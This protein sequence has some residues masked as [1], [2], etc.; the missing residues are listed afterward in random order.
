[1]SD[2][3]YKLLKENW[4]NYIKEDQ[5]NLEEIQIPGINLILTNLEP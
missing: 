1:M 3:Q 4:D 5:E 2:K